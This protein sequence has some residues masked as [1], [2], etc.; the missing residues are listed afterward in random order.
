MQQAT[1]PEQQAAVS[2]VRAYVALGGSISRQTAFWLLKA[3][4]AAQAN[5]ARLEGDVA[6]L[7]EKAHQDD[8]ATYWLS[9]RLTGHLSI[10]ER[11][12][13]LLRMEAKRL[14]HALRQ[15]AASHHDAVEAA[16]AG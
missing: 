8:S 16:C 5:V 6:E 1:C 4:D 9:E 11:D 12:N 2:A 7:K 13:D 10:V 14:K 3:L 15:L